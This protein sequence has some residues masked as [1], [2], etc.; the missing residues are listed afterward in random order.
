M[1]QK[2]TWCVQLFWI[3]KS[4]S[5]RKFRPTA[6]TVKQVPV[7]PVW[8]AVDSRVRIWLPSSG[9][10]PTRFPSLNPS[11][12]RS[13]S[14]RRFSGQCLRCE[15]TI[16][17]LEGTENGQGAGYGNGS[18]GTQENG[19]DTIFLSANQSAN[20]TP[21]N[22]VPAPEPTRSSTTGQRN[23]KQMFS[24]TVGKVFG[25]VQRE[26]ATYCRFH[27]VDTPPKTASAHSFAQQF[28]TPR[29]FEQLPKGKN[30]TINSDLNE[31]Y[32]ISNNVSILLPCL[33]K[34]C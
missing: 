9:R 21:Q 32:T 13:I 16:D 22:I 26:E 10:K 19:G 18:E 20:E 34:N 27:N 12:R 31:E 3:L 30:V 2:T 8:P 24:D 4:F 33:P 1:R 25:R 11:G 14:S 6:K 5:G 15:G 17:L 29:E 28:P 23:M 7:R